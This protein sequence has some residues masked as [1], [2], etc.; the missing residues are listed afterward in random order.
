MSEN[1]LDVL[2][3]GAGPVGLFCANELSRHG[4][5]CRIV[6]KKSEISSQS[7]ALAIH[8]R[9]L[10]LLEDCG[11]LDEILSQGLKVEGVMIKSQGKELINASFADLEG[12]RHFFIDLPQNKTEQIFCNGLLSKGLE[13]EWNTELTGI[14]QTTN[15]VVA[16]LQRANGSQEK[17]H[18][19]WVIACDGSHST[20]R[21]LLYAKFLG[22]SYKQTFW[23]ADIHIN[24][25]FPEHKILVYMSDKGPLA[26]FPMGEQRYRLVMTAPEKITHQQPTM[27]DIKELFNL[28]STD[29]A[30]LSDAIW[31]SPFGI[32][33][34]QIEKYRYGRVFF[35]G[36]AAHV[37]SPMGGQGM[38]TGMQDIYN[39][40][41]KL[42]LVHKGFAPEKLLDSYQS[43]R[44]PIA[45]NVLKKT[46]VM[47]QML[48]LS[49]PILIRLRNKFLQAMVSLK[50]VRR[51]ILKDLAELDISYDNS[52]IVK[53][54]GKKTRF[55]VGEFLNDFSLTDTQGKKKQFHQITQGTQHH[56]F[57]FTGLANSQLSTLLDTALGIG[58]QYQGLIQTHL[59]LLNP[60]ND[61]FQSHLVWIDTDQSIHKKF[62]ILQPTAV[63]IRPD[64]YLGITQTPVNQEELLRHLQNGYINKTS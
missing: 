13:V 44:R 8:I 58:Q 64:K 63:L 6:D 22:S 53:V 51:I 21:Q 4:L 16:S 17:I 31:I 49:N 47:T 14:E 20:L 15:N 9:S 2:V 62:G 45:K 32:D 56:L 37:H 29:K 23:L 57:L 33:H 3:V 40:A 12:N 19:S 55:K 38:N 39:L 52:P 28:R 41:W 50:P 54:L 1:L 18:A 25:D 34:R 10:D 59:V 11:F 43:E 26:C 48:L 60:T 24:W 36:D 42:A 61:A 35:A 46:G 5:R 7:K 27:E 30:T